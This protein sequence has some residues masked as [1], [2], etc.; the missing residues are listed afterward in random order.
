MC[1]YLLADHRG[2]DLLFLAA[3]AGDSGL[4]DFIID[5]CGIKTT[6]D[7]KMAVDI[8]YEKGHYE[9]VL[10]LLKSNSRFPHNFKVPKDFEYPKSFQNLL[11]FQL[12]FMMQYAKMILQ[13]FRQLSKKI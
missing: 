3:E 11:R 6:V 12:K 4:L 1:S 5:I 9:I 13:Q 7:G 8:A 10:I 2:Y